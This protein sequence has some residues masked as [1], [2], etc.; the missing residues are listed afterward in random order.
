[1][2]INTVKKVGR[3]VGSADLKMEKLFKSSLKVFGNKGFEATTLTEIAQEA[4]ITRSSINYHFGN[5][6][7]LWK[8]TKIW[9][10]SVY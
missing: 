7:E 1:M 9:T 5:K 2:S 10:I 4:N 6:T 8:K 3:P